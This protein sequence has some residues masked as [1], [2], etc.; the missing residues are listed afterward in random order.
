MKSSEGLFID[1]AAHALVAMAEAD[2]SLQP[3]GTIVQPTGGNTGVSLAMIAAARG[4]KC[5]LTIPENI[6]PDKARKL[7]PLANI[8]LF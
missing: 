3:G 7:V 1:R 5:H 4:Y 6:S 8:D 2:G